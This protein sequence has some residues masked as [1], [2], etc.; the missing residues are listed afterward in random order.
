MKQK[1]KLWILIG[2]GS[3]ILSGL[4]ILIYALD[5]ELFLPPHPNI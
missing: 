1:T 5:I 3:I 4:V 2:V